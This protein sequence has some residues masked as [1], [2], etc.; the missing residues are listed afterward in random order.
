MENDFFFSRKIVTTSDGSHTL[1]L[2]GIDE[3][4]HSVHGALQE[5]SHVF[6]QHGLLAAE[7]L[8]GPLH[9][10][11]VGFGTG[12]NALLTLDHANRHRQHIS[13][14]ALEPFPLEEN[15]Y[16]LLN[17]PEV[18]HAP[19][20]QDLYLQMHQGAWG[21]QLNIGSNF[22]LEKQQQ[23]LQDAVLPGEAFHLVYF[24]AFAPE[25]QP[26]MWTFEVF[27]KIA[28][29]MKKGG[30]LVT[31]CAKGEVRRAMKAAGLQVEKLPGPPGKREMT[32]ARRML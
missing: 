24:D 17:F 8:P 4:Y 20:M 26:G 15:E 14:L 19:A 22:I 23:K 21:R 2:G 16:S 6:I 3:H 32:R 25:V 30:I 28:G 18:M 7:P 9:I 13:Y 29:S 11:E 12:L 31:Y 27:E 10:L 5:S 1:Q